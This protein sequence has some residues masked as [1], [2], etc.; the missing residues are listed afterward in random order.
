MK[1]HFF[2]ITGLLG[3]SVLILCFQNCSDM[4]VQD[5]VVYQSSLAEYAQ[6]ADSKNLNTLLSTDRLVYS[7]K[8]GSKTLEKLFNGERYS[9][10]IVA[11]RNTTGQLISINSGSD[12]EEGRVVISSGKILA[13]H[14]SDS[15]R[16]SVLQTNVPSTG[17]KMVIAVSFGIQPK[18]IT[19]LVNGVVQN[20]TIT[21]T[22][23]PT[24]FS[25][26][27]KHVTLGA[28]VIDAM[29]Y[30]VPYDEDL[31]LTAPQLNVVSRY[32]ASQDNVPNVIYDP[33]LMT[34]D[35]GSGSGT[36]VDPYLVAAKAVIDARCL[37]CHQSGSSYGSLEGL[38][39]GKAISGRWVVA[40]NPTASPLYNRLIGSSGSGTKDMP[41][42][43]G[44]LTAAQIQ[45]IYDWILNI[46]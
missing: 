28:G 3:A 36:T 20:G 30:S 31:L 11:N 35:D 8:G 18:E 9:A 34:I 44:A 13:Y 29:I 46:K 25:Y 17:D 41:K 21:S 37:D 27:L 33:S 4:V 1:K 40:G 24:E 26:I 10:I 38:T 2:K 12:S 14:F 19:L 22:G 16:Y 15:S 6:I 43:G 32:M 5:S 23:V 39:N 7:A 42:S 45:T